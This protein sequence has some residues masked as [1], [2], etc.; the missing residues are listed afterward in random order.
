MRKSHGSFGAHRIKDASSPPFQV[1]EYSRFKYGSRSVA[2]QFGYELSEQFI[3]RLTMPSTE[4]N[5]LF[6]DLKQAFST[7]Q[8]VVIPSPYDFIPTATFAMKDYFLCHFNEWL[9]AEGF[10]PCQEAKI[11]R[12]RSYHMD[13]GKMSAEERRLS[14]S[15]DHFHTD[16]EFLS[17]KF[18]L[19][20]DDIRITGGHEERIEEMVERLDIDCDYMHLYYGF[21]VDPEASP[22][23]E[24]EY[25]HASAKSLYDISWIIRNEQFSWNTRVTKFILSAPEAEFC[26]FISYQS[27][28]FQEKLAHYAR[29]NRYHDLPEFSLNYNHLVKGTWKIFTSSSRSV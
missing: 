27:E 8:I 7:K 17:N 6:V 29:G 9:I 4:F 14:I 2:K 11:H 28:A 25:N 24:H 20:M 26:Q 15:G 21:L 13:Y 16:R 12:E 5:P 23:V 3:K 19:F 18:V 1:N 10:S 22:T